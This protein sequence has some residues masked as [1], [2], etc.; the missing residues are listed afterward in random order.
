M[1]A[2]YWNLLDVE[3]VIISR[4]RSDTITSHRLFPYATLCVPK[5]ESKDYAHIP[6]KQ[7]H[8]PDNVKGLGPV[9]N[10]VLDTFKNEVV[11]MIDD[12]VMKLRAACGLHTRNITDPEMIRQIVY[13]TAV[14]AKDLG[15][16][17]FGFSQNPNAT[18]YKA[19]EPFSFVGYGGGVIGVVG[20]KHRFIENMFKVDVDFCLQ[21]MMEDRV[22]WIDN[23]YSFVQHRNR[24]KGGNSLFRTKEKQD[25][26]IEGLRKKWG[27]HFRYEESKAGEKT[28]I[29]VQRRQ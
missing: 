18:H 12:D 19:S 7:K 6:L 1:D 4:G 9:R 17:C 29:L 5:S 27:A 20:R 22:V 23:Q 24:N 2:N 28:T 16:S 10:W 13:R 14:C 25:A 8:V 3:F 15:T 11:V 21:V 26:E